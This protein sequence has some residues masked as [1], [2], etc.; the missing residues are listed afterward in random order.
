MA[1]RVSQ[2]RSIERIEVKFYNPV[3]LQMLHLFKRNGSAQQAPRLGIL[4][5]ALE[6]LD[7]PARYR[8]AA[9]AREPLNL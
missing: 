7:D 5:Q 3:S 8:R 6:P 4:I 9:P 2:F 1:D